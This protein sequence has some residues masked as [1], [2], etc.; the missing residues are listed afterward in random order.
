M[1]KGQFLIRGEV[2]DPWFDVAEGPV[3]AIEWLVEFVRKVTEIEK[4]AQQPALASKP[5]ELSSLIRPTAILDALRQQT[6]RATKTPIV[7]LSLVFGIGEEHANAIYV[8]DIA[9]S[10]AVIQGNKVAPMQK[11]D[12]I[13]IKCTSCS[14][15]WEKVSPEEMA[16]LVTI[17]LYS[18]TE[19][20]KFVVALPTQCQ[21]EAKIFS[22]AGTAF[23]LNR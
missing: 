14:F 1:S 13:L 8:T 11:D 16:K 23:I 5:I 19:R 17:P 4:L 20:S 3:V 18:N 6:S 10:G 21:G 12:Q 7:D 15:S 22:F 9:L 2:P